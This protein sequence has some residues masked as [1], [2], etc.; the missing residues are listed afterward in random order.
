VVAEFSPE[1]FVQVARIFSARLCS[2]VLLALSCNHR[3]ARRAK[4]PR[5]K[6]VIVQDAVRLIFLN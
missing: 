1:T 2:A 5:E 6:R 4:R 3:R